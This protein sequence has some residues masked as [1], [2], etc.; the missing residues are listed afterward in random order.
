[1]S[2]KQAVGFPYQT[3]M[4]RS[5]SNTQMSKSKGETSVDKQVKVVIDRS[6]SHNSKSTI[7]KTNR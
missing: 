5:R 6:I 1:M 4:N 3:Q 2:K 7:E